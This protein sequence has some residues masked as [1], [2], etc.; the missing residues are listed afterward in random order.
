MND[1][2]ALKDLARRWVAAMNAHDLDA[3]TAM[4][5]EDLVNHA[6]LPE[7][8]GIS[9]LRRIVDKLFRAMPDLR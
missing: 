5:R 2:E 1:T 9:G 4:A 6:A 8:Q 7:A 3:L